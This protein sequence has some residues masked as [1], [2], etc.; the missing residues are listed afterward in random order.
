M[1]LLLN[2]YH[3]SHQVFDELV[4]RIPN[5]RDRAILTVI[6]RPRCQWEGD[7]WEAD[8]EREGVRA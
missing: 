1:T 4:K 2:I 6:V 7:E 3:V 5:A 8:D